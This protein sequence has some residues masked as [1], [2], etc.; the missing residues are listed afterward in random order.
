[1]LKGDIMRLKSLVQIGVVFLICIIG[2]LIS[3]LLP[4]A[5]PGSVIAMLVLFVLL[6][7]GILKTE[8]IKD[9]TDF[10]L[11]NMA[12]FFIPSSVGIIN[13]YSNIKSVIIPFVFICIITTL[14]TFLATAYTVKAV[15]KL[16]SIIKE[17]RGK[18]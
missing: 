11:N 14:I 8:H 13:Y 16:Q 1:M 6:F 7:F 3:K 15:M 2:E 9:K 18:E 5:F 12:F 4:F 10:M 17:S